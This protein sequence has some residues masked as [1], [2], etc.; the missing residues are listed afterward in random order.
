MPRASTQNIIE[1]GAFALR[2]TTP[3]RAWPPAIQSFERR[4]KS[5]GA[6]KV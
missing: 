2:E 5:C 3:Q 4:K 6:K 1:V